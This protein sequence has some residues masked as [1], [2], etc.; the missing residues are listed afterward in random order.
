M[1]FL[2][3]F[4]AKLITAIYLRGFRDFLLKKLHWV[5]KFKSQLVFLA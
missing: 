3:S 5:V 4:Q 2:I 1:I